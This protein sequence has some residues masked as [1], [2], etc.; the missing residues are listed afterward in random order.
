M[1]VFIT[2]LRH[3][4]NSNSY[5]RTLALLDQTLHSVCNQTSTDFRVLVVCNQA[6]PLVPREHVRYVV[7]DFP[8]PS[9]KNHAC[10][11]M[12][13]L[14]LDRGCKYL[15]GLVHARGLAPDHV[16]FFDADDFISNRIAALANDHPRHDG[17]F[18]RD[19][20]VFD[21]ELGRLGLLGNFQEICGT[22]HVVSYGLY[23][24]PADFP[25]DASQGYIL[26]H[27][28]HHY[29]FRILG[30]HRW[31]AA[32]AR[33]RGKPLVPLPFRGAVYYIGHGENHTSRLVSHA[34]WA[35]GVEGLVLTD[36]QMLAEIREEFGLRQLGQ[37]AS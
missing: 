24:V 30:S 8:P 33:Q 28:D 21:E 20:Y 19:G 35:G 26:E 31:L 14:R 13:A 22:S 4:Q 18:I 10:T 37:G 2:S 34:L 16:M 3:P 12:D 1:I 29:L 36:P 17:W 7:V 23:D 9:D 32:H 15:T 27:I 5:E 25:E 11:G 6:P